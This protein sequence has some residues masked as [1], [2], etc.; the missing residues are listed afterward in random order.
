MVKVVKLRVPPVDP[1]PMTLT[2]QIFEEIR[3]WRL[4]HNEAITKEDLQWYY[5]ALEQDKKDEIQFFEANPTVK[6]MIDSIIEGKTEEERDKA[7]NSVRKE[8]PNDLGPMPSY[9]TP[10]FWSW[11]RR[12]KQIRLEKEAAIIAAGGTV[13]VKKPKKTKKPT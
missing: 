6:A 9:G 8:D 13:E 10:E 1:N 7:E 12:R 11:C 4:N 2:G 5:D 3:T